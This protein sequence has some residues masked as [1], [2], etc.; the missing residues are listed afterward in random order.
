M[1]NWQMRKEFELE[2]INEYGVW[3]IRLTADK[4]THGDVYRLRIHWAGGEGDRIPA[5]N[6]RVVQD[7]KTLIFNAQ[8][9]LPPQPY[10]WKKPDFKRPKEV[11]L[12]YESHIGM[13][14]EE[15]KIGTFREFTLG[16][17]PREP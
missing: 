13:A 11:P 17:L 15:E 7:P 16:V 2:K 6:R 12:I 3:E 1:S 9:W 10:L 14:L 8:L 4:L 5:Y